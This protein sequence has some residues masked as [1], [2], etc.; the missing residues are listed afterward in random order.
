MRLVQDGVASV[1]RQH[2]VRS[3]QYELSV[4]GAFALADRARQLLNQQL[5]D[6]EN[7]IFPEEGMWM[8]HVIDRIIEAGKHKRE[9]ESKRESKGESN[10]RNQQ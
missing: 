1:P 4:A 6:I 7:S 9:R 5:H 2:G 10:G 3:M 8:E